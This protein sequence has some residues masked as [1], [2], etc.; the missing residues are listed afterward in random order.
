MCQDEH[1]GLAVVKEKSKKVRNCEGH[2]ICT[3]LKEYLASYL[4]DEKPCNFFNK[5]KTK[6]DLC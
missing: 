1:A 3:W 5:G 4:Y 6:L 2:S